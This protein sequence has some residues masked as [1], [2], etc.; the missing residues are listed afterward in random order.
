M[1]LSFDLFQV[2]PART[3]ARRSTFCAGEIV[4]HDGEAAVV[5][6][7]SQ[8]RGL[9]LRSLGGGRWYAEPEECEPLY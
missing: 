4:R 2:P 1:C 5:I 3:T 6:K 9:L 7:F 8:E